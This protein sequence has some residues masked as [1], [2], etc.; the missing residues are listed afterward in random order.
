MSAAL[1]STLA[2][3]TVSGSGSVNAT[4]TNAPALAALQAIGTTTEVIGVGDITALG[5]LFIKNTD[6][7]NF[8]M[9]GLATPVTAPDAMITLLPGQFCMFPTRLETIYAKADT[10]ACNCQVVA[11]SL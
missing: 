8:V 2:G 9:I 10:A 4:Q 11:I 1:S 7:T 3:F 6:A 5:Y